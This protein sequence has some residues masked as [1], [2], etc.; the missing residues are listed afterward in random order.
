VTPLVIPETQPLLFESADDPFPRKVTKTLAEALHATR[1]AVMNAQSSG[2]F[3][4]FEEVV[5]RG[6]NANLCEAV[7]GFLTATGQAGRIGM[8][9]AWAPILPAPEPERQPIEFVHEEIAVLTRA[10][11]AYRILASACS[12]HQTRFGRRAIHWR[13]YATAR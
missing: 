8:D 9:V 13:L 5:E 1:T 4:I 7:A 10:D 12:T 2:H 3:E 11:I 6:V